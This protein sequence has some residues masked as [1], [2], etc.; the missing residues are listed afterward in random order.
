MLSGRFGTVVFR[1]TYFSRDIDSRRARF[2]EENRARSPV[3]I[4]PGPKPLSV[5]FTA[6]QSRDHGNVT[7]EGCLNSMRSIIGSTMV[8]RGEHNARDPARG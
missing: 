7:E 4:A 8:A 1:A 2:C 3:A 5:S 6:A